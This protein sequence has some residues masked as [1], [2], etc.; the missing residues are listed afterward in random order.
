MASPLGRACGTQGRHEKC[1]QGF[2]GEPDGKRP[3]GRPR[4][5]REDN[6]EM[7][8]Q[9]GMGFIWPRTGTCGGLP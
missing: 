4:R 2:G 5:K 9:A 7:D 6:I 1:I 3:L 8:L